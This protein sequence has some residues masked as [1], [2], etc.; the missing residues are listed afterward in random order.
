MSGE[1]LDTTIL[2]SR[3]GNDETQAELRE[4]NKRILDQHKD[5]R[6]KGGVPYGKEYWFPGPG[7]AFEDEKGKRGDGRPGGRWGDLVYELPDGRLVV[8]QH[9]DVDENG[10]V[11][12]HE[13]DAARAISRPG[14][15]V[16]IV[17][18]QW[19]LELNR[20]KAERKQ[21]RKSE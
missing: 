1:L 20:R 11:K 18:K 14:V 3:W 6:L 4:L 9:A 13:L 12:Q 10:K 16:Y 7:S 8:F 2:E 17:P 21:D 19:Q 5:W 15:T